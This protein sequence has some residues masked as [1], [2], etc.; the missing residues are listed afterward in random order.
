[1]PHFVNEKKALLALA[2]IS[3]GILILTQTKLFAAPIIISEKG[4]GLL[5]LSMALLIIG[6]RL[7]AKAIRRV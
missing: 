5:L 3:L 4:L 2:L 6:S 1:M 7:I